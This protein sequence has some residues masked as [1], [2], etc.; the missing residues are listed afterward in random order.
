MKAASDFAN[1]WVAS[2]NQRDIESIMSHYSNDIVFRSPR[3]AARHAVTGVGSASGELRGLD[4][5][6]TYFSEA[7]ANL[8]VWYSVFAFWV[9]LV[10]VLPDP[11]LW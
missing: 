8:K 11:C 2:W 3:V 4:S 9:L 5:L 10:K 7:L 6:R 1:K